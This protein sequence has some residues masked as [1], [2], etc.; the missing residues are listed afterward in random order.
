MTQFGIPSDDGFGRVYWVTGLAGSGKSTLGRGLWQ[1]LRESGRAAIFLDGDMLREV[2][3]DDLGYSLED[4]RK[5][6][7]R[8]SRLCRLL[9]DQGLDVVCATIS[10]FHSCR[11]WN[12]THIRNYVEVFVKAPREVLFARDQKQL[13]S[14]ALRGDIGNVMGMDLSIEE[15]EQPDIVLDNDGTFAPDIMVDKLVSAIEGL[16]T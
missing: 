1:R 7:M 5:S 2:F 13:Y 6:A 12:R 3:G 9:S 15:P 8:N 4:R 11:V 16:G 14:M 10:M